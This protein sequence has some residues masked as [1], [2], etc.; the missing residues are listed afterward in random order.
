MVSDAPRIR[1]L[2]LADIPAALRAGWDDFMAMPTQ[3]VF[4]CLIYPVAG[5][6]LARAASRADW[7]S[8]VYPLLAGFALL[9]PAFAVGLYE[10]SRRREAGEAPRW[11]DMFK[12][13]ASPALFPMLALS[14]LLLGLFVAWIAVAKEL[15]V[16]IMGHA[17]PP[18]IWAMLRDVTDRPEGL[19][20][21][22]LGNAVGAVFALAA[23]A[24]SALSFPLLLDRA[25]P[26]GTAIRTS[27]AALLANPVPMLAW[28]LTVALLLALG[29]AT[30]MVG[31]AVVLPV[32]GHATWHLY[33]RA[34]A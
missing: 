29:F 32:L 13:M 15:Y 28:G 8:L 12:V 34:V 33:R 11:T 23:F 21:I 22:L 6:V 16:G 19:R 14:A 3:L 2:T 1:R 27:V 20:L 10:L 25:P 4:L 17:A 5:F 31:L 24:L 26:L 18:S 30:V 7:V 9:G